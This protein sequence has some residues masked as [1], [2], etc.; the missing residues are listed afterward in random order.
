MFDFTK[1]GLSIGAIYA[2]AYALKSA[3]VKLKYFAASEFGVWWPF[4]DNNLLYGLDAFRQALGVPL[5]I[6]P[7]SGAIG[8]VGKEDE[9]SQ[10]FLLESGQLRA[11]DIL[12]PENISL[13]HAYNVAK[14][15][16]IF[17]GIGVYPDWSPRHG[18]HLDTRK[19]KAPDNPATWS[20][21]KV[22]IGGKVK[23][24]YENVERGFV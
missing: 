15:L 6:S 20:G 17:T 11:I 13:E 22:V 21:L 3:A 5:Q 16:G 2:A 18:L 10:H 8:R 7:A 12:I 1:I 4:L 9:A 14:S 23:Q 24:V 19:N